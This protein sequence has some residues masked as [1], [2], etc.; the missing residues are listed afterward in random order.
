MTKTLRFALAA[1]LALA[2]AACGSATE[3]S[4]EI[5]GEAIAAIAAPEGTEW[6]STAVMTEAGGVLVGNPDAPLKLIEY[7]SLTCP[8]CA[9]FSME[10]GEPLMEYVDT[11]VVSFELR[12][13]AI[14]GPLDLLLQQM[15]QCG[16]VEAAVPL[17]DQ[18]W[19]NY[20]TIM[21]PIQTNQAAFEAAMQRPMEERFVVAAEQMGYLDFFAARG[22]SEDQGRQCLADVGKLEA[23]A[24][25][26]QRYGSEFDISGTPT[27]KLND[28][29][30]DANTWAALEPI[31]QRAG[32]R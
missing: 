5:E 6:R 19:A 23:M 14:H 22:I 16:P 30:V 13:F 8:T 26:T 1:P 21:Q 11:G 32:A 27:F 29:D 12:Q 24:D 25:Y 18:V 15:T 7:G 9:R 4:G 17:S 2:L 3:E 10:G 31:L 28:R 20:E